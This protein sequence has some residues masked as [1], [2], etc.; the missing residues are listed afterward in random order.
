M[1]KSFAAKAIV[2]PAIAVTGFVILCCIL[3]YS[4]IKTDMLND[5]IRHETNLAGTIVRSTRYAMLKDDRE[6]LRNIIDNVGRQQGVE[7]VRIFNKKGVIAFSAHHGEVNTLVDKKEPGCIACHAGPVAETSMG[8]MEQGRRFIN[9]RGKS[10]IAITAPIYNEPECFNAACHVHTAGQKVLG[11]L[12]I[13]LSETPLQQTLATL[14]NRM[15]VFSLM[16]LLLAVGGVSALLRRN[17]LMPIR[18]LWE[19]VFRV[20]RGELDLQPP[21]CRDELGDLARSFQKMARKIK[22][23]HDEP[24]RRPGAAGPPNGAPPAGS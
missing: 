20:E 2:P 17:V 9:D 18:E 24:D 23:T 5:A 11:I 14:R 8:R 3:L 22:S 4:V 21:D 16:V 19:Y 6:T 10:V 1:L 12:D 13:G 7:Q 15:I